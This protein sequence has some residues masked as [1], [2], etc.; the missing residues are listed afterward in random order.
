MSRE[1]AA[2]AGLAAAISLRMVHRL[3]ALK[4]RRER[5]SNPRG[6]RNPLDSKNRA[7]SSKAARRATVVSRISPD[8]RKLRTSMPTTNG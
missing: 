2:P 8:I 7:A 1:A 3:L 6:S 4:K 5:S